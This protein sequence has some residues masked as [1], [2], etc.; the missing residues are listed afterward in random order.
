V[1]AELPGYS[2]KDIDVKYAPGV[3]TIKGEREQ[4]TEEKKK[5]YHLSERRFGSFHRSF[6]IPDGIQADKVEAKFKDGVL[7]V[8]LPKTAEAKTKEKAI[9]VNAK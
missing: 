7:T 6:S 5:D 4:T 9:P 2:E 1:S 3:L 8:T